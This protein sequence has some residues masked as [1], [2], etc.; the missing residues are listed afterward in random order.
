[1]SY[2][3]NGVTRSGVATSGVKP[4]SSV[5]MEVPS[6]R[7]SVPT[8]GV[9]TPTADIFFGRATGT[10]APPSAISPG[11]RESHQSSLSTPPHPALSGF[12][13]ASH[14]SATSTTPITATASS[15]SRKSPHV[16][17]YHSLA[18]R[19]SVSPS[20]MYSPE[21]PAKSRHVAEPH[22]ISTAVP[23]TSRFSITPP[24]DSRVHI[25]ASRVPEPHSMT[26]G[27]VKGR[28]SGTPP[29]DSHV[30][31]SRH[32]TGTPPARELKESSKYDPLIKKSS[33][34]PAFN[35]SKQFPKSPVTFQKGKKLID[36]V[37][38]MDCTSS[39][40]DFI[41]AAKKSIGQ[42]AA[43]VNKTDAHVRFGYV[44]YR[45]HRDEFVTKCHDFVENPE[46][47]SHIISLYGAYGGEDGPEAVTAA[48]NEAM[49]F[50]WRNDAA[51]V[52]VLIADAPPHG[53][54]PQ[55]SI[56]D[57]MDR[58][59]YPEGDPSGLDPIAI[60][61]TMALRGITFHVVAVEPM[62]SMFEG[63]HDLMQGLA[64]ITDGRYL[65]LTSSHLLPEIITSAAQEELSL[66]DAE[67]VVT[68][69]YRKMKEAKMSN[70]KIAENIETMLSSR[71][72]KT[73]QMS[74]PNIYGSYNRS[75]VDSVLKSRNLKTATA[76]MKKI[77][78]PA[79]NFS[80][81]H[82]TSIKESA[83]PVSKIISRCEKRSVVSGSL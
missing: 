72:M 54:V 73:N 53:I 26:A 32:S 59:S 15:A 57:E 4:P 68:Q 8:T 81:D 76:S 45:D 31:R 3:S 17:G 80:S 78:Q 67:K 47:M 12:S 38:C 9:M 63:A 30:S 49:L 35:S 58:D 18:S 25:S 22:S 39:M 42:I 33:R 51:K 29:H 48:M 65:P 74:V 23:A 24:R 7:S 83:V 71:K 6:T 69:S 82:R 75:N 36:I 37:F 10:T 46:E 52:V 20:N 1:M 79:I 56:S 50:R 64:E 60:A 55:T 41:E 2:V 28:H 66:F 77:S 61:R 14:T 21:A 19:T 34:A 44:A 5:R 70:E 62:L 40:G 43:K 13:R 11:V 27:S 16:G